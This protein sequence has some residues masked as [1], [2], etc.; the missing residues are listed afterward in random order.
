MAYV[1]K[2]G[3]QLAIVQGEREPGT[4]KVQQ[5]VL[6]TISSR[7][8]AL[9]ILGRGESKRSLNFERLFER[10]YPDVRVNWDAIRRGIEENLDFLPEVAEYGT[11]R[12]RARFREGLCAFAK[13]LMLADPQWLVSSA[14]LIE[15]HRHE[16]AYI[17]EL[18]EWRLKLRQQAPNEWNQDNPFHWRFVLRGRAVPPEIEGQ[19]ASFYER[20]EYEKA[21][22]I[23]RLLVD[24][25]DGYADGYNYLGLIAYEQDRL[26]DALALFEKA[27]E[28]G[29][30]LFPARIAKKR[31]WDDL[32]TRPYMRGLRN[33]AMTLNEVGRYDEALAICDRL[34]EECGDEVYPASYRAAVF[35]NTG[36]WE[37]AVGEAR[38][39][40]GDFD[41]SAGFVEAL[42]LFELGRHEELLPVFLHAALRYPRAA[43]MLVGERTNAPDGHD[44]AVDHNVGVSLRRSLRAFLRKQSR[45]SRAF[46]RAVV[47]DPRVAGL[48]D[49]LAAVVRR[50]HGG[51]ATGQRTAFDRMQLMRSRPFA[52]A[53]AGKLADLLPLS[54]RRPAELH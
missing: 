25:F 39:S 40:G 23:F 27:V 32:D 6:F 54:R 29:R 49:E 10:Q 50:W 43:R 19:V 11:E 9:E 47:R 14:G 45:G 36:E 51:H 28:V 53:E 48:L 18:I 1:R 3:N 17:A 26:E 35:L 42:A 44:E 8:E 30:K 13:Q 46:F 12:V 16:L 20:G 52:V 2:R 34:E 22:A 21:E 37:R 5:R 31:Y 15:E 33:L 41:P 38:R 24:T 7:A 4:G